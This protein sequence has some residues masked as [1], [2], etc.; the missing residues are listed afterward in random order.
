MPCSM[1]SINIRQP[2][3]GAGTQPQ[4][5]MRRT[6]AQAHA[7][8]PMTVDPNVATADAEMLHLQNTLKQLRENT[9]A[10]QVAKAAELAVI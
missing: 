3:Q 7:V 4:H 1:A 8:M 5:M 10:A 6:V 9:M 2:A